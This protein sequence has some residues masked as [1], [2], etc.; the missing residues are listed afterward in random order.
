MTDQLTTEDLDLI[1]ESLRYTKQVRSEHKYD[2][3]EFKQA[4]V[5]R[6]ESVI[7]KIRAIRNAKPR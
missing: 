7:E 3:Y 6:L 5:A 1:L 2:S 4:Q